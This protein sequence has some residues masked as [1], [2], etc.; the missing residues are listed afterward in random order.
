MNPDFD[1]EK[2]YTALEMAQL[3]GSR[4]KN[5]FLLEILKQNNNGKAE[6]LR[7]LKYS[8]DK[9][10]LYQYLM[11]DESWDWDKKYIFVFS[12]PDKKC[13]LL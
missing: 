2:I 13:E 4:P 12:D 3:I 1:K 10:N 5:W 9:E 11:E 7:F 6:E 8:G